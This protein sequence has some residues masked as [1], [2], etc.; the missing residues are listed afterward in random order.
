MAKYLKTNSFWRLEKKYHNASPVWRSIC[1]IRDYMKVAVCWSVGSGHDIKIWCDPWVPS[2]PGFRVEGLDHARA[3]VFRVS[4]LIYHD[5]KRWKEE[6][7]RYCFPLYEADAILRIQ[8]TLDDAPDKLLWLKTSSGAF[9]TKSAYT[10]VPQA[11]PSSSSSNKANLDF[12]WKN[13][14]KLRGISP[15]VQ[16]FFMACYDEIHSIKKYSC[17]IY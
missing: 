10:V 12:N 17:P 8:L 3:L 11:E 6:L 9:T 16:L 4:D 13:L 7:I 14:W 5:S 2:L 15:R 1:S